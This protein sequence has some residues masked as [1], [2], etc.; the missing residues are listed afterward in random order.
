MV[1]IPGDVMQLLNDKDTVKVLATVNK[2]G[3]PNAVPVYSIMC[4]DEDT[5]GFAE[6]FIKKTKQNLEETKK[7]AVLGIKGGR[8]FQ[9]KGTFQGFQNSGPV[10]DLFAK[11]IMGALNLKIKSVGTIKIDEIYSATPGEGIKKSA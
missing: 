7:A 3:I 8:A 10:F 9:L 6:I 1:K 5:I 4:I 2:D 11:N